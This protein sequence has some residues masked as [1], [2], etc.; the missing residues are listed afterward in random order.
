MQLNSQATIR[1]RIN[2]TIDVDHY[3]D[4]AIVMR[5]RASIEMMQAA[6]P[7]IWGL[8]LCFALLFCVAIVAPHRTFSQ[9]AMQ[10]E[11][12]KAAPG[13]WR[14]AEMAVPAANRR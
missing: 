11:P 6:R 12:V 3:R 13:A 2:G 1:R 9:V 10:S 4:D 5:R 14:G 7:V 8:T